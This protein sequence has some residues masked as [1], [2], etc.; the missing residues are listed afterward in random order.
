MGFSYSQYGLC[1][2]FCGKSKPQDNVKKIA[3]P[4]GWC[5]AWACC[6]VCKSKKL[7]LQS[8]CGGTTHKDTC[9]QLA[10]EHQ[11]K[12]D[13]KQALIESGYF[14]RVAALS[15]GKMCKVIFRG[16]DSQEKAFWMSNETYELIPI[17]QNATV[18]TY[19]RVGKLEPCTN[20]EIYDAEQYAE[21]LA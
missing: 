5:Q 2:D 1:C 7:H 17:G 4:H 21:V 9:K 12:Q 18:E 16:K 8:S 10:I 14:L 13:E 15:H 3:C 19:E 11:K 20:T 6:K